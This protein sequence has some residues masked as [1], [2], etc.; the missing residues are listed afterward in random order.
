M[1]AD[2][3][4]I[5]W[6]RVLEL[7]ELAEGRVKAVTCGQRT[8]CMSRFEGDYG[9]LDNKCPHQGGPLGEGSIENGL[10]RCPW[11]GWDFHPLT[12]RAPGG[13][14]D[15]V[16]SFPVEVREDGVYVGLDAES[17]H[18]R[19][20]S[21]VVAETLVNWGIKQVWGM[22]GHSNLGLADAL[23]RRAEAG[24]LSYYGIR[25]E[26]AAS[27]AASAYGKLTGRPAA[28]LSIAGPG[29]TNLLTGLWDANV[30]RSPVLAL[31]GQVDTQV[32]G[33]GAF[34]EVDLGA[35]FGKV[36]RWTQTVLPGSRHAELVN[37]AARTSI[38]ERG[39]SHL[40]FPDEVQTLAAAEGT[41]AGSPTGRLTRRTISPP[42]ESLAEALDLLRRSRRPMI[43]V[44]HGAR[45]E[46]REVVALA[47]LLDCPVATTFK[48]KGLISDR[49]PL[50][51]GVLGRSGTPIASWFM[52]EADC[53]LVLGASFS[54]H[55]GITPKK[56]T[57]QVD[58][59]PMT[60]A[61]FHAVDVPV[62]GEIGVTVDLLRNALAAD[63]V[64]E[65]QQAEI[66]ERWAIWR[67][68]KAKRRAETSGQGLSSA[69]VFDTLQRRVPED[70]ILAVDVGNNTYSFGRYFECARQAVLMSGYLGSIGFAFPAAMGAWA[71]TQEAS[72]PFHGRKVVS[73]SGDGG[74]A[75]Y[76]AELTTAVKYGMNITHV[77]L[78]NMELGK[79]SKE[80]RSADLEVWQTN[81]WNPH[82]GLWARNC[83]AMGVRVTEADSLDE[84]LA[85]ALGHPGASLVE[86]MTDPALV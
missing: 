86:V 59:D 55:T 58:Y 39:V 67:S 68:E 17:D 36:A 54:N 78:N 38:L 32:L 51:C 19:T 24:E 47:E 64:A 57:I 9:A 34:Q 12:G 82:F 70:A 56:P 30:D 79:I 15:A 60:L 1:P 6:H 43:I 27:F 83:G 69:L 20:V 62:W 77:L 25:H 18:R 21:D 35:A 5:V 11:H 45:F 63:Q 14:D 75:Q 3:D 71:A 40:V 73:I 41:A 66:A 7:G 42:T 46:M 50:G 13:F 76:M 31:T 22:V 44:G 23:R 52:N 80:Q 53:L 85:R 74:F 2:R 72:S 33:P 65:S 61:R 49:H 16:E 48:G 81:L 8:L 26:G 10:L 29:A 84:A 4:N 28:C 37:L